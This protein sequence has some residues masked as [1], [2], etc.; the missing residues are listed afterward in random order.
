MHGLGVLYSHSV[1]FG[2][3]SENVSVAG[4]FCQPVHFGQFGQK[5]TSWEFFIRNWYIFA[6]VGENVPGRRFFFLAHTFW[7]FGGKLY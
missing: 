3:F 2:H 5:C 6:I 7:P 4:F 1:D